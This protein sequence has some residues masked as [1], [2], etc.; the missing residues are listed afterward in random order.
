MVASLASVAALW[1]KPMTDAKNS[2]NDAENRQTDNYSKEGG[3]NG[4]RVDTETSPQSKDSDGYET[5]DNCSSKDGVEEKS[6][7]IDTTMKGKANKL[8]LSVT[9]WLRRKGIFVNKFRDRLFDAVCLLISLGFSV[10]ILVY[11]LLFETSYV[12]PTEE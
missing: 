3:N 8:F 4:S 7:T 1:L 11:T 10:F 9:L 12:P 6:D 2:I 5:K